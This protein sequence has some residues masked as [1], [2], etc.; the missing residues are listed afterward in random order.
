MYDNRKS[1]YSHWGFLTFHSVHSFYHFR[2]CTH[3]TYFLRAPQID[4]KVKTRKGYN[5]AETK[6]QADLRHTSKT[7]L[8]PFAESL[9]FYRDFLTRGKIS[10]EASNSQQ[11]LFFVSF[12]HAVTVSAAKGLTCLSYS[13]I[14]FS[15]SKS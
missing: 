12:N 1:F 6:I 8:R 2:K 13:L 9:I 3:K 15:N 4:H 10:A 7:G 5:L 14:N 11:L